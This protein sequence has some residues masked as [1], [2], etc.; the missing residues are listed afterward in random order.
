MEKGLYSHF[1]HIGCHLYNASDSLQFDGCLEIPEIGRTHSKPNEAWNILP[2]MPQAG[3]SPN[4]QES[5]DWDLRLK[6][7]QDSFCL[8]SYYHRFALRYSDITSPFRDLNKKGSITSS[9]VAWNVSTGLCSGESCTFWWSTLKSC[10]HYMILSLFLSFWQVV[11][12]SPWSGT[13]P[14]LIRI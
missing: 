6:G 8:L 5:S 11:N 13:T 2:N 14:C 1:Y 9:P 12:K 3:L 7:R 10:L 4:W